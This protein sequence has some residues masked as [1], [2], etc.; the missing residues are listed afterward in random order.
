MQVRRLFRK[1]STVIADN[2]LPW[3]ESSDRFMARCTQCQLCKTQCPEKIIIIGH[4]GFPIVDFS[5]GECTFCGLCAEQ[6][7]EGIFNDTEQF[8]WSKKAVVDD[9]CLANEGVDCR[10]CQDSCLEEV[11]SFEMESHS[12]PHIDVNTCHGCGAC[13]AA[14]PTLA[15]TIK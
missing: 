15:I 2:L 4:A 13:V 6:C 3:I 14:C 5:L 9:S 1:K 12:M 10:L 7:R 11:I 8:P